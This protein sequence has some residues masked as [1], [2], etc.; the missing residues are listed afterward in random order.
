M[1]HWRDLVPEL[2]YAKL[3]AC[4]ILSSAAINHAANYLLTKPA[5]IICGGSLTGQS[6]LIL[7]MYGDS[8]MEGAVNI[9][10][11]IV[12]PKENAPYQLQKLLPMATV[13]NQGLSGDNASNWINRDGETIPP[14]TWD[15]EMRTSKAQVIVMNWGINDAFQLTTKEF[16]QA[17][18]KLIQ[19]AIRAGKTV[20]IE[21]PNPVNQAVNQQVAKALPAIVQIDKELA[22]KYNLLLID[23]FGACTHQLAWNSLLSDGVHP[24][25]EG[26]KFKAQVEFNQ[27]ALNQISHLSVPSARAQKGTDATGPK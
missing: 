12:F 6:N 11:K 27:I 7:G 13:I 3:A 26:Y 25:V 18:E 2:Y 15:D 24:S 22:L 8:T 4:I 9:N 10:G 21:T 16:R 23:E 14:C 1:K 19:G 5:K 17:M 20:V